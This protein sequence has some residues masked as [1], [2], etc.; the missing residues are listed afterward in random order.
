MSKGSFNLSLGEVKSSAGFT[1]TTGRLVQG[2]IGTLAYP[3]LGLTDDFGLTRKIR[4]GKIA[5]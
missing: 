3:K 5:T 4:Y 2:Q 1:K